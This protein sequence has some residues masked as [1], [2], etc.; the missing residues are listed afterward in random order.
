[1]A[2]VRSIKTHI[3]THSINVTFYWFST[4]FKVIISIYEYSMPLEFMRTL[5]SIYIYKSNEFGV[6]FF[7]FFIRFELEF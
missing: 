4:E 6:C 3:Y 2:S 5:L 1:M 7:F